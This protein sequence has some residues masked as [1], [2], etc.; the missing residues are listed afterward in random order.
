MT[1]SGTP[2]TSTT[3]ASTSASNCLT[4][5]TGWSG[6]AAAPGAACTCNLGFTTSDINTCVS[7]C[8]AGYYKDTGLGG[9]NNQLTCV[10]C[11]IACTTC[12]GTPSTITIA[13]S[14]S[15]T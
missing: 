8:T 14:T 9:S 7:Y 11:N 5:Y 10:L 15:A 12:Y 3:V 6:G 1:C 2:S 4:C 13:A